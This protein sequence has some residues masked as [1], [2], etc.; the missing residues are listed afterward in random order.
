MAEKPQNTEQLRAQA[1][2]LLSQA[3]AQAFDI[4]R[5]LSASNISSELRSRLAGAAAQISGITSELSQALG[6]P[7]FP[8]RPA[9][10]MTLAGE[11]QAGDASSLV[12]EATAQAAVN[13]AAAGNLATASAATRSEVQSLSRDLFDRKIFDPYLHFS[14][15]EDEAEYRKRQAE[16]QRYINEQLARHTPDGDLRAAEV[17]ERAMLDAKDHGAGASPQFAPDLSELHERMEQ[18][19]AAMPARSRSDTDRAAGSDPSTS[20]PRVAATSGA[21]TKDAS[22][23]I[24]FDAMDAK[25]AAAGLQAPPPA[26]TTG[27]GLSVQKPATK[28][29]LTITG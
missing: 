4:Q 28:P 17:T 29:T 18:L 3:Q 15:A 14:S 6:S 21:G 20:L 8:L 25:L 9:D 5:A 7:S 22:A 23:G 2:L 13:P 11:V 24:D 26:E 12:A 16:D 27:H 10:L 1:A 19:R